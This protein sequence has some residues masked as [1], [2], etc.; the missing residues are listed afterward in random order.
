MSRLSKVVLAM[1][2]SV[3]YTPAF[4]HD[5]VL[6]ENDCHTVT[7]G[8]RLVGLHCHPQ[9]ESELDDV[10]LIIGAA[11]LTLAA[12]AW[13]LDEMQAPSPGATLLDPSSDD[14]LWRI[15]SSKDRIGIR[16]EIPLP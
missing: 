9:D 2:L 1:M 11:V 16:F 10:Y 3:P 12:V 4:S 8:G 13:L 5:G 15:D 6:D 7:S 14:R